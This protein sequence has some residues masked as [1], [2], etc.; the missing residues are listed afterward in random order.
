MFD[1]L[2]QLHRFTAAQANV[3]PQALSELKA[4]QKQGHWMWFI[5]PQ[6]DGLGRSETAQFYAVRNAEEAAAYLNH[7]VLGLRLIECSE[8][9]LAVDDKSAREIFGSPDDMKLCSSM[10]LFAAVS[11]TNPVFAGVIDR[12]FGGQP[13]SQT[14]NLLAGAAPAPQ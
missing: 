4:G 12:Y 10:T 9:I 7:P 11:P 6:I 3:Y 13:D 5:F 8:A 2:F 1:D 14:L